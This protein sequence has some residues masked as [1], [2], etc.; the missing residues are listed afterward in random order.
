MK[1]NHHHQEWN[2]WMGGQEDNVLDSRGCQGKGSIYFL[3]ISFSSP[4]L[5]LIL[6]SHPPPHGLDPYFLGFIR[7]SNKYRNRMH[8]FYWVSRKSLDPIFL[9]SCESR[10]SFLSLVLTY[11]SSSLTPG[12]MSLIP[13]S[14]K[15]IQDS[16]LLISWPQRPLLFLLFFCPS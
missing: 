15:F 8:T 11:S 7:Y 3:R 14:F 1:R 4:P 6:T 13:F 16:L 2:E 10:A 9:L 12:S 5:P